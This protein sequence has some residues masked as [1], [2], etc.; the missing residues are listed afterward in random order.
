MENENRGVAVYCKCNKIIY[1][2]SDQCLKSDKDSQ[3]EIDAYFDKGYRIG[4]VSK[5]DVTKLF[6][7]DCTKK[8]PCPKPLTIRQLIDAPKSCL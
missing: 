4:R 1:V 6:G 3:N 5:L 7:C 2:A 8:E